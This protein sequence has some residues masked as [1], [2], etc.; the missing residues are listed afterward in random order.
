MA[1]Q[2]ECY[3]YERTVQPPVINGLSQNQRRG[4]GRQCSLGR[5]MRFEINFSPLT[6]KKNPTKP[7]SKYAEQKIEI[8]ISLNIDQ[9]I[10]TYIIF[11][12]FWAEESE[13]RIH[14]YPKNFFHKIL[15]SLIFE[16]SEKWKNSIKKFL[17]K[18]G[19]NIRI[20]RPKNI[21]NDVC[22]SFSVNI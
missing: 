20:P 17:G 15:R 18:N 8:F 2:H 13:Y 21:E 14:F 11:Y 4:G 1:V 12:V 16:N 7:I 19:C 10:L 6:R 22:A 5:M 9:K 3:Y